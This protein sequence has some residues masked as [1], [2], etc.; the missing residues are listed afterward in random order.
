[1]EV[2]VI[3]LLQSPCLLSLEEKY[4]SA[5]KETSRKKGKQEAQEGK[6]L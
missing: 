4:L 2:K 5:L 6:Q 3:L 1:M